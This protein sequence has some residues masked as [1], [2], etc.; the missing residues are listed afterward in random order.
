MNIFFP[1][2]TFKYSSN[3]R[4]EEI[5]H[6]IKDTL[7]L[8]DKTVNILNNNTFTITEDFSYWKFKESFM[9]VLN[10]TI[11]DR[12]SW[13][14]WSTLEVSMKVKKWKKLFNH[15]IFFL[16]ILIWVSV[17]NQWLTFTY[18]YL[19]QLIFVMVIVFISLFYIPTRISYIFEAREVRNT[20]EKIVGDKLISSID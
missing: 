10:C 2:K 9:L 6:N 14:W 8:N 18:G 12:V 5:F 1:R 15:I 3:L 13:K 20:L 16:I 7:P 17:Y 19:K 11:E 4:N